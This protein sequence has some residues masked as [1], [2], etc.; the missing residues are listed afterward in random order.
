MDDS[1]RIIDVGYGGKQRAVG[2]WL[3][4]GDT[5]VDCGS[6]ACLDAL[7]AGLGDE[8]PSRL[9][10]THIHFDH[11]GAAGALVRMWPE[12]E[13]WVH[14][15]GAPH[16]VDPTR[17]VGSA[18][19]VF[20]EH[21]D[22]LV[23]EVVPVPEANIRLIDDGAL[24][25]DF[26]A[27]WTP[28]HAR[29]HVAFLDRRSGV[30]YPGDVAGVALAPGVVIPP[31][32]PPDIDLDAWRASLARVAAW[33]P[34][35]F[36]LPHFGAV[37]DAPGHLRLIS[38]ALDRHEAWARRGA[39]VFQR[40]LVAWLG[41]RIPPQVAADYSFVALGGPSAAGLIRW[42]ERSGQAADSPSDP[43]TT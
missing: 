32:P 43:P 14:P 11:A 37:E 18:R 1:A 15:L 21:F 29:H 27:A 10:L 25:G 9:L 34:A 3:R 5:L 33:S 6:Q 41:E 19:R 23:G 17:L 8:R 12:L 20:G 28:G 26:E 42:L 38:Q 36:A 4:G 7:I 30:C 24:L 31:T 35:S 39:D 16:L 40:E 13:V 2:A 22:G